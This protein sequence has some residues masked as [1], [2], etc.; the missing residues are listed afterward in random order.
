MVHARTSLKLE[1][2]SRLPPGSLHSLS[3]GSAFLTSDKSLS[4][5]YNPAL[6]GG[7]PFKDNLACFYSL[8]LIFFFFVCV[9]RIYLL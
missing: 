3:D 1:S 7:L 5:I 2:R 6:G 9:S 4:V 8:F